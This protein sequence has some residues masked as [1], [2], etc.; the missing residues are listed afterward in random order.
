MLVIFSDNLNDLDFECKL[1]SNIYNNRSA[2][3]D[4]YSIMKNVT[5]N[6]AFAGC[7]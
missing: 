5:D 2:E 7:P 3:S 1:R 6:R 4:L